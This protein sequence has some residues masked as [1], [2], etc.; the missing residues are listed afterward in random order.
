MASMVIEQDVEKLISTLGDE[1][2]ISIQL[3]PSATVEIPMSTNQMVSIPTPS[4]LIGLGVSDNTLASIIEKS[5][6]KTGMP[7]QKTTISGSTINTLNLPLPIPVPISLTFATHKGMLLIGSNNKV[8]TDAINAY[9]KKNG[10]IAESSFKKA[11]AELP[12]KNNGLSYVSQRFAETIA[13]VQEKIMTSAPSTL[14]PKNIEMFKKMM[15]TNSFGPSA[16]VILN[17]KSGIQSHGVGAYGGNQL[18]AGAA[19]VPIGM[20]AGIAI[21]SLVKARNTSKQNACISNLRQLDSAKEQAAMANNWT[22][23]KAIE[24]GSPEE[25][26]MLQYI[27]GGTPTCPGGGTYTYGSIGTMPICSNPEHALR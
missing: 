17:W 18:I 15:K 3:S 23:G 16:G 7:L 9:T 2:F 21:P 4:I 8:V 27:K 25:A 12:L 14:D 5:I 26:N 19:V 20:M 1:N 22:D 13:E 24:P 11:F 10:L 6:T